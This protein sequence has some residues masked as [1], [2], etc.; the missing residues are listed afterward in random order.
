MGSVLLRGGGNCGHVAV[1]LLRPGRRMAALAGAP[2]RRRRSGDGPGYAATPQ[3][4][5]LAHL[6][7]RYNPGLLL[8]SARQ[9]RVLYPA[10]ASTARDY[11]RL[12]TLQIWF[13]AGEKPPPAVRDNRTGQ[14]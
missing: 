2:N 3:L 13:P 4:G 7:V 9:A 5:T 8:D 10:G 12:C 6:V 1:D 11:R 14:R